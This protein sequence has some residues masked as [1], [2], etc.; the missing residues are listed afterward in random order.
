[1]S[2]AIA[3]LATALSGPAS[4]EGYPQQNLAA[5]EPVSHGSI[6]ERQSADQV[7]PADTVAIDTSARWL[8]ATAL[9]GLIASAFALFGANRLLQFL[10]SAGS[11]LGNG[12]TKAASATWSATKSTTAAMGRAGVKIAQKPMRVLFL[13]G[14]LTLFA[15]TGIAW[16]DVEWQV[17]LLTG[18][19]I[20][21]A[22]T[23]GFDKTGKFFKNLKHK[24]SVLRR[25]EQPQATA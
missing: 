5:S 25:K 18:A 21:G 4:A 11:W 16:F 3:A 23:Y 6:L 8:A 12:T 24:A 20:T 10:A 17:G 2:A 7:I 13:V 14:G 22:A 19:G 1:M 15:F 9:S